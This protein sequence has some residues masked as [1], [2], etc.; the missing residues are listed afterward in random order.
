[1]Q[2]AGWRAIVFLCC[3]RGKSVSRLIER[4]AAVRL[5][6][7]ESGDYPGCMPPIEE[8]HDVCEELLAS[9]TMKREREV[10]SAQTKESGHGYERVGEDGQILIGRARLQ[11]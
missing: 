7:D 9:I 5:D 11:C 4:L 6:L 2:C 10:C 1:M 8:R 3:S